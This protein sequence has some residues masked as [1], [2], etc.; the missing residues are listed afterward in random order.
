ML[1]NQYVR[2]LKAVYEILCVTSLLLYA[3]LTSVLSCDELL[4]LSN[5]SYFQKKQM[6]LCDRRKASNDIVCFRKVNDYCCH[7]ALWR[8]MF[9]H[10][11]CFVFGFWVFFRNV[12]VETEEKNEHHVL[13]LWWRHC[14]D[15]TVSIN[16]QNL[17]TIKIWN[18]RSLWN[19]C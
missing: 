3:L 18:R 4:L 15:S 13:F 17:Y 5:R 11:V 1:I 6:F 2:R 9:W 16:V 10:S 8:S 12:R 19:V 7:S 14:R